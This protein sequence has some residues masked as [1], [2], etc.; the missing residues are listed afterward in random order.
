[1]TIKL[2][3][4]FSPFT[5]TDCNPKPTRVRALGSTV[6]QVS[7]GGDHTVAV[8]TDGV[9]VAGSNAMGQ[10]GLGESVPRPPYPLHKH[11]Y[12]DY[13]KRTR[14]THTHAHTHTRSRARAHSGFT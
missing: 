14:A 4:S 10:L 13:K 6:L 7:A 9:Y 2:T 3:Q 1:M 11:H 8:T 5:G 12:H